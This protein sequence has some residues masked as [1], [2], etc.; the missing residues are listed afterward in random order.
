MKRTH[1]LR[2]FKIQVCNQAIIA[3]NAANIARQYELCPKMVNRW[4]K[5]YKT[6]NTVV[7]Q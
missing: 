6:E 5:E 3:G 7:K 4:V 2:E 1:Y